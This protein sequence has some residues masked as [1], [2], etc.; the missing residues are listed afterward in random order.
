MEALSCQ[1]QLVS[2]DVTQS[3]VVASLGSGGLLGVPFFF[4]SGAGVR[5]PVKRAQLLRSL[6]GMEC[7][8]R[9]Q[10]PA[11]MCQK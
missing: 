7:H 2:V 8:E 9:K 11:G 10:V 4:F 6:L 1:S 5:A 3:L